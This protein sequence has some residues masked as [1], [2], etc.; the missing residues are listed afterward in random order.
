MSRALAA[1]LGAGLLATLSV[2][3]TALKSYAPG[4]SDSGIKIGQTMPD[5]G[6]Y[7]RDRLPGREQLQLAQFDGKRWVRFGELLGE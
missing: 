1:V 7:Q 4:V 5:P 2:N 6:Q 3:V